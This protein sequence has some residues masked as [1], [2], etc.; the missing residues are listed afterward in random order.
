MYS[1]PPHPATSTLRV[2]ACKTEHVVGRDA[3]RKECHELYG[4]VPQAAGE[5][6]FRVSLSK[7]LVDAIALVV[8]ANAAE[9]AAG[10]P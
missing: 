7:W 2:P 6:N 8:A 5:V 4:P 3:Q 10:T 1:C 9:A